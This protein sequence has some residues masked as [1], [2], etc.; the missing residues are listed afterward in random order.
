VYD[1]SRSI[2]SVRCFTEAFLTAFGPDRGNLLGNTAGVY[3]RKSMNL[4]K[5]AYFALLG[6][7]GQALGRSYSRF[8]REAQEGIPAD[9]AKNLLVKL[10]THCRESVPY[11]AS[12][13]KGRKDSFEKDPEEYLRSFPVLTKDIIRRNF[14]ALKSSDLTMRKWYFNTSGGS[15]GEPARFIQDRDYST[16]SGAVKL[17]YSRLV[18]GK[19]VGESEI[20][21][22]SSLR[23]VERSKKGQIAHWVNKLAN[24]QI[25]ST[26]RLDPK[27]IGRYIKI[28]NETKP[29][30]ILAYPYAMYRIARFAEQTNLSVVPQ[31]T[32]MVSAGTL[33]PHMRD[34]IERVFQSRVFDR[35]GSREVGDI[36]CERPGHDGFWVAPWANYLEIADRGGNRVAEGTS[37]E[38]FVTSLSNY[39]M[40]LI[41]YQIGDRG[42]LG[43]KDK[44]NCQ[45]LSGLLG[46]S[47]DAFIN[48]RGSLVNSGYFM[49]ILYF[50]DWIS[51]YQVVQKSPDCILF[52]FV[53][54]GN[55]IREAEL[56]DIS[57]KA[58]HLMDDDDCDI[59]FEFV[60]EIPAT[61]SG[62]Y[63]FLISEVNR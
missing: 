13:M 49:V 1:G 63:H 40:P 61:S 51:Q 48:S 26:V 27:V 3:G 54:S 21:L 28:L 46:R 15:T 34:T 35:Y 19:E 50:R 2:A 8:L 14:E 58:K 53:K 29:K 57:A 30:L 38:I 43:P 10:L 45:M 11:Y 6:L 55:E 56:A 52:R 9:T 32:I 24:I 16:K 12:I 42:T 37:G 17:L 59:R 36:A 41:R 44:D 47:F 33:Y 62:K 4:R 20:L 22:W 7:R 18:A 60:D 31:K 39:A 5:H 25:L 23:D